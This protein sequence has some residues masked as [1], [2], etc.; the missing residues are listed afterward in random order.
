MGLVTGGRDEGFYRL[1]GKSREKSLRNGNIAETFGWNGSGDGERQNSAR[2]PI[3][4]RL[5]S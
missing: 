2:I 1:S 5:R 3:E 4:I